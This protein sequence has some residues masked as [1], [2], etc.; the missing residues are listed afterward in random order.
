MYVVLFLMET[1]VIV[2]QQNEESHS[3]DREVKWVTNNPTTPRVG[4]VA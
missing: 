4:L 3:G 1:T 2:M